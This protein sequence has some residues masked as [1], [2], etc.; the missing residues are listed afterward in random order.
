MVEESL[1]KNMKKLWLNV[2]LKTK[3]EYAKPIK[4]QVL[5]FNGAGRNSEVFYEYIEKS[6]TSIIETVDV[7]INI[8][9]YILALINK[10][11]YY[12]FY[13]NYVNPK[14]FLTFIDNSSTFLS[15]KAP[16]ICKKISVQNGYRSA[17][18][19]MYDEKTVKYKNFPSNDYAFLYNSALASKYESIVPCKTF[20]T[21]SFISNKNKIVKQD[22]NEILYISAF[23]VKYTKPNDY[24]GPHILWSDYVENEIKL[25]QWLFRYCVKKNLS[26]TIL[27]ST[28]KTTE[29]LNEKL[30]YKKHSKG[31]NF[32]F[33]SNSDN[34]KTYEIVDKAGTIISIDSTLGYEALARGCKVAMFAGIRGTAYP[35]NTRKFGWPTDIIETG[36]FWTGSMVVGQWEIVMKYVVNSTYEQWHNECE[37]YINQVMA[38]DSNNSKFVSLLDKIN[39]SN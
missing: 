34:R 3:I 21:G 29:I 30:F 19:D 26:V 10:E 13:L 14:I 39:S 7:K 11:N 17:L 31:V 32:N 8:Y 38:I 4:S 18:S 33:I 23:R 16:S 1:G 9:I 6:K 27:G 22:N 35:L 15:L 24:C 37:S 28:K 12:Q 36:P 2:L 25:L 5:I 20:V